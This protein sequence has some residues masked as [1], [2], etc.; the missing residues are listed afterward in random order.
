MLG[1]FGLPLGVWEGPRLVIVALTGLFS[2]L[3][4]NFITAYEKPQ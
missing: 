1:L 2:N 4:A 3:F